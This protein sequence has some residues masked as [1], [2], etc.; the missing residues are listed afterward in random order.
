[1]CV[2]ILPIRSISLKTYSHKRNI[3]RERSR[4]DWHE[5]TMAAI[6]TCP[7]C[8]GYWGRG[9]CQ[10]GQ[11]LAEGLARACSTMELRSKAAAS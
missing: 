11:E 5:D 9:G 8:V 2:T 6:A 1:M 10:R 3:K 7:W 4:P